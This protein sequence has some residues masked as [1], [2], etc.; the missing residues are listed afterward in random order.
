VLRQSFSQT[1]MWLRLSLVKGSRFQ[2]LH[3]SRDVIP[4]VRAIRSSSDGETYRCRREGLEVTIDHP[5]TVRGRELRRDVVVLEA[6]MRR[7]HGERMDR[8]AGQ[9]TLELRG[10]DLDDEA[11]SWVPDVD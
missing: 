7:G 8:L 10:V 4:A 6:K 9:Q 5:V 1:E 11:A 3:R 2:S